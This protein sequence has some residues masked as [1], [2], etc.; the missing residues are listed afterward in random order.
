MN[1]SRQIPVALAL[2]LFFSSC[3]PRR[4]EIALRPSEVPPS[5]LVELVDAADAKLVSMT[6]RGTITFESPETAG[7]ASF[8]ISLRK[9]DSLLLALEGPFGIDVGTLFLSRP[10]F[11]M[12]NS[13]ENRVITGVPTASAIRSVVP[14]DLTYD[15]ILNAFTGAFPI[16]EGGSTPLSYTV[17]DEQFRLVFACGTDSCSYWIDPADLLV[18]HYLR[19]N[20]RGEVLVEAVSSGTVEDGGARMPRRITVS[21]PGEN[22]RVTIYFSRVTLNP[23]SISFAFTIPPN[24]RR[25]VR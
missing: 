6:G 18:R 25:T 14:F 3:S 17:D 20:S 22:R 8:D 13:M 4:S 15:Q 7:S 9:P 16:A 5:R 11:I 23:P 21:F 12:Y 1:A 10:L 19:Q 2:L 24:A